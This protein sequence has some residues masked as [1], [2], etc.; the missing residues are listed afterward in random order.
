MNP[1]VTVTKAKNVSEVYHM[2]HFYF[3]VIWTAQGNFL[4]I[5]STDDT[6]M[7]NTCIFWVLLQGR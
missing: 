4:T 2:M 7:R 5:N 3:A 1:L 6:M